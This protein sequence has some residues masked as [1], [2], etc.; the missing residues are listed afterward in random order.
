M[1]TRKKRAYLQSDVRRPQNSR[2]YIQNKNV[3]FFNIFLFL[4][5]IIFVYLPQNS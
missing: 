3:S 2:F 1:K 4:N 5:N